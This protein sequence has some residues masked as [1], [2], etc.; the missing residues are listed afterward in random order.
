MQNN[1][2]N[3]ES[4]IKVID[5]RFISS[6]SN[7][8]NA[9]FELHTEI[10]ILGRSN[11]GK[12][13]LINLL[14]DSKNLAKSSSTPGKTRLINFFTSSWMKDNIKY[15][16]RFIDFPGFGFAKVSKEL[17]KQWDR[18]LSIFIR[19]R[20]S[21]KL[22]LH[23]IDSRHINL[24]LDSNIRDFLISLNRKDAFILEVFTKADKINRNDY[25]KL[26][27]LGAQL[28]SYKNRDSID[29]LRNRILNGI[30]SQ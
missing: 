21:I 23:L 15:D 13:T 22:F 28:V 4:K 1:L 7:I 3:N 25:F 30:F 27:H 10:A 12:S 9:P 11:V 14:L 29:I 17:K 20:S 24:D 26:K 6:A 18:N 19:N 16:L 5:S 2:Q 8:Q